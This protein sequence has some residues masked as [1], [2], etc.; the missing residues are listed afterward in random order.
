MSERRTVCLPPDLH[1]R[2]GFWRASIARLASN[3]G[4]APFCRLLTIARLLHDSAYVKERLMSAT[5]AEEVLDV[6]RTRE[7]AALD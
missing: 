2:K 1:P 7:Q 5:S 3:C 6:I 4:R